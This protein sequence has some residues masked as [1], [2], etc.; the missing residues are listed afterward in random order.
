MTT[1][2]IIK[3]QVASLKELKKM[4]E[5]GTITQQMYDDGCKVINQKAAEMM[6]RA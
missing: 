6:L 1:Q 4:L 2:E 3:Q 5:N